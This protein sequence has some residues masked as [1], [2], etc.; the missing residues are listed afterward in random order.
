MRLITS[1]L[2]VVPALAIATLHSG[3]GSEKLNR[4]IHSVSSEWQQPYPNQ[5]F[6]SFSM[7]CTIMFVNK[8]AKKVTLGESKLCSTVHTHVFSYCPVLILYTF[9]GAFCVPGTVLSWPETSGI[10]SCGMHTKKPS[11]EDMW[12]P[13]CCFLLIIWCLHTRERK[14][15][16]T[17]ISLLW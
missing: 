10:I 3:W 15:Q 17:Q 11:D 1:Q 4:F 9:S 13:L 12:S 2:G 16:S 6:F 7:T 14:W 8:L 5:L